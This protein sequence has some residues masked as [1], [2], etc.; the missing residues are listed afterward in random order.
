MSGWLETTELDSFD[1]CVSMCDMGVRSIIYTD[2]SRDGAMKGTNIDAYR[3]LAEIEGLD[4]VA[5]G[6]ISSEDEIVELCGIT[7]GAILGKSLYDG[8]LDLT[9]CIVLAGP[10]D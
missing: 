4:I 6:G 8:V 3:K 7:W 9:K 10:Q 5:S 1:F 2:I